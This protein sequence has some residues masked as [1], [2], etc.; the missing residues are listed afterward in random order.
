MGSRQNQN[1]LYFGNV[2]FSVDESL[3]LEVF[4]DCGPIVD[5]QM[6]RDPDT[7]RS[8]GYGFISLQDA[9]QV[10]KALR[11]NG[12]K[13]QN[14][15]IKVN[16]AKSRYDTDI[17]NRIFIAKIPEDYSEEDVMKI[18]SHCPGT[19][20]IFFIYDHS[21]KRKH[22]GFG[23]MDFSTEQGVQEALKV[24]GMNFPNST[25]R[26]IVQRAKRHQSKQKMQISQYSKVS[27]VQPPIQI[28]QSLI[29]Q[30]PNP[31]GQMVPATYQHVMPASYQPMQTSYVPMR[32]VTNPTPQTPQV[33][34]TITNPLYT[35]A[36]GVYYESVLQSNSD[37]NF[38]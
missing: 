24:H 11:K 29:Q 1:R 7:G 14:R 10:P 3:M 12:M 16:Y 38:Y 13:I 20:S 2:P 30:G 32:V 33:A 4:E 9:S 37:L 36:P 26:M 34:C 27:T 23:F 19:K 17:N 31:Y 8:Q 6:I 21:I 22:R 35:M 15:H 18:F 5:L 28:N 25:Q